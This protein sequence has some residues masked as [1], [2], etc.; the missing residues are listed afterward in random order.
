MRC[1]YKYN[2]IFY[3]III[4]LSS[5]VLI[6]DNTYDIEVCKEH[7]RNR[8]GGELYLYIECYAFADKWRVNLGNDI[9]CDCYAE[10]FNRN[11]YVM[12]PVIGDGEFRIE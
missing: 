8:L 12:M 2:L 1:D 3:L 11:K 7:A 9:Y 4:L 5:S 10:N 6:I